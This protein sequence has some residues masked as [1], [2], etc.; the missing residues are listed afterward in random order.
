M[1]SG[2]TD[3]KKAILK[4]LAFFDIF[5]YPLTEMEVHKWLWEKKASFSEVQVALEVLV[6]AEIVGY[7]DGLYFMPGKEQY[8]ADR[9]R[10]YV[11]AETKYKKIRRAVKLLEIVPFIRFIGACNTLSILD[12]SEESDL[13]VFIIV[14][15]G[16]LWMARLAATC[17]M[18]TTGNWRH[19]KKVKDRICLSFYIT[20][21]TLSLKHIALAGKDPYL[22]YWV[23]FIVPMLD[24]GVY[25]D[26]VRA[27]KWILTVI[28]NM[29]PYVSLAK[30]RKVKESVVL[31]S[32]RKDVE[33]MLSTWFGDAIEK[34]CRSIQRK[35]M[36]KRE[37]EQGNRNRAIIISDSMLKFH[38]IDR[39]E[40]YREQ[41][42]LRQK[43]FV[44]K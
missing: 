6:N 42:Y 12:F 24:R 39:R 27:N 26:F 36:E 29:I 5:S 43:E 44:N 11:R 22:T 28:P 41:W 1:S 31:R 16:R 23:T 33:W 2:D 14:K 40:R 3:T 7:R 8:I 4:T 21:D 13:D 38:E 9:R 37:E 34:I 30:R 15:K 17:I 20:T 19:G 25:T 32:I 35:K 18:F 10:N